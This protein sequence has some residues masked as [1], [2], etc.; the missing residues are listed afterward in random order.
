MQLM[1]Q[2]SRHVRAA[3]YLPICALRCESNVPPILCCNSR[4]NQLAAPPDISAVAK[5]K[6]SA[7]W[8]VDG[9]AGVVSADRSSAI[10]AALVD[11]GDI[12]VSACAQVDECF[13]F[14]FRHFALELL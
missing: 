11:D 7:N 1:M 6:K 12:P 5:E 13:F 8:G 14:C 4:P 2:L 9:G 10:S 3:P